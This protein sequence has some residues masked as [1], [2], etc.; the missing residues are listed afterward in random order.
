[1][2]SRGQLDHI[3]DIQSEDSLVHAYRRACLNRVTSVHDTLKTKNKGSSYRAK[4]GL[5]G[6]L[7]PGH[8]FTA[9]R[10]LGT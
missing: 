5:W 9:D 8:V 3:T 6:E 2:L 10:L 4:V 7:L 1:M